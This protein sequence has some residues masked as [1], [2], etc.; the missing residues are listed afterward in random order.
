MAKLFAQRLI[1]GRSAAVALG[2]ATAGILQVAVPATASASSS[3]ITIIQDGGATGPTADATFRQFRALGASTARIILPWSQIA[4]DPRSFAKPNFDATNPNAYPGVNWAP[5]DDAVRASAKYHVGIDFTVTGGAPQWAEAKVPIPGGWDPFFAFKPNAS[6]YGK[7][8]TAIGRRYSGTFVPPGQTQALPRVRFWAIFNE[9]NFGED[10]GPQALGGSRTPYAPMLYRKI[11]NAGWNALHSTG[12][13]H[14]TILIGG[15]AARGMWGG[16]F[17]GNFAQ[18]KPLLFIRYLYCL[19]KNNQQ[20][21]GRTAKAWGC[22]TTRAASRK[23]RRQNPAL[24]NASGMADHPYPDNGSPVSDGR[25]DPNWATFPGLGRLG[26][27]VDKVVRK[28]GSRKHYAIYND[29]YGY[30]TRPPANRS[31]AGHLYVSPDTAAYY[32]NWAEYLSWKMGRLKSYMQYLLQDPT[33]AAGPYA[34]FASGLI[35]PS[36]VRKATY[37]AFNLPVYMPKTSFSHRRAVEVWGDARAARFEGGRQ[38]QIQFQKGGIGGFQTLKTV[39]K[40]KRGGYFDV[41]MKFPSSGVVRLA[42]TYAQDPLLPAGMA[43]STIFSR[44]FKI[45]VH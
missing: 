33:K 14:D 13:G 32:I 18:T 29:E 38:V 24:F 20:V 2:I 8:M 6:E 34:G 12:H 4:P 41:H 17:P 43:G 5:Y 35:F 23:F 44:T 15:Y 11:L 40:L 37:P 36:G 30:I 16:K 9:P 28:Y 1:K 21:R 10:L 27:L 39:T 45:K 19:N 25:G 3:Q 31:P 42:F 26:A 22:P 7:F